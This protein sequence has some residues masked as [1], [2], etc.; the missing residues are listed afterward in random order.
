MHA[1]TRCAWTPL[2]TGAGARTPLITSAGAWMP[3]VTGTGVRQLSL[4]HRR[5]CMGL[6]A[7]NSP[8]PFPAL[9]LPSYPTPMDN[10]LIRA[11]DRVLT[12]SGEDPNKGKHCI[13]SLPEEN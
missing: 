2:V 9:Y 6:S 12:L 3:L 1:S 10:E 5:Q 8:S 11:L 13:L 4:S 7:I